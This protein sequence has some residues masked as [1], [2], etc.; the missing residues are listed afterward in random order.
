[1]EYPWFRQM[2]KQVGDLEEY[3]SED[4]EFCQLAREAGFKIFIDPQMVVGHE[5]MRILT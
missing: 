1:M 4:V 2:K 3:C 5:K